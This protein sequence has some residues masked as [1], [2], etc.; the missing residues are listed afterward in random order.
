MNHAFQ[1]HARETNNIHSTYI[2]SEERDNGERMEGG[3]EI[4]G[5][6]TEDKKIRSKRSFSN[7]RTSD[8]Q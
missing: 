3:E 5:D 8:G 6:L 4:V 2:R 7:Y 1:F